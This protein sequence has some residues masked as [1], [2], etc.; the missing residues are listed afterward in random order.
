VDVPTAASA[1]VIDV[2][3]AGVEYDAF[4]AAHCV[5]AGGSLATGSAIILEDGL[6]GG[7]AGEPNT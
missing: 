6:T 3:A 4:E 2:C 7:A 1:I 5:I